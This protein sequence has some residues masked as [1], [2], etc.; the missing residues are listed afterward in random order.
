MLLS[1]H[2]VTVVTSRVSIPTWHHPQSLLT[3]GQVHHPTLLLTGQMWPPALPLG[4]LEEVSGDLGHTCLSHHTTT[5]RFMRERVHLQ[6]RDITAFC[7]CC[8]GT[9]E[10]HPGEKWRNLWS[11]LLEVGKRRCFYSD[12][13][14]EAICQFHWVSARLIDY[15][16]NNQTSL[17]KCEMNTSLE[18]MFTLFYL[19][20]KM[21]AYWS[22]D[23]LAALT[24]F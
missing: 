15:S 8:W 19:E 11:Q 10:G 20:H 18:S 22:P 16:N 17:W 12:N 5:C 4:V 24:V 3:S 1:E 14:R 13:A 9:N 6:C 23:I 7:K 21:D 2:P